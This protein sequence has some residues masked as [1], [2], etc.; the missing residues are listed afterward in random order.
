[1]QKARLSSDKGD[2]QETISEQL[3]KV[4]GEKA[5]AVVSS[6][7]E[8]IDWTA[9]IAWGFGVLSYLVGWRLDERGRL[10]RAETRLMNFRGLEAIL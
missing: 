5:E 1:M 3:T 6:S 8:G 10:K 9:W 2:T 7:S 4:R